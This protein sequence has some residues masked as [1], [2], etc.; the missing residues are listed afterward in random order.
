MA[1]QVAM[2]APA[3]SKKHI[4][5][6]CVQIRS[7][8]QMFKKRN[9]VR[10]AEFIKTE[11]FEEA[12]Q[13]AVAAELPKLME[14][15]L[16][17][18]PGATAAEVKEHEKQQVAKIT[19]KVSKQR[20]MRLSQDIFP[21]LEDWISRNM[22]RMRQLQPVFFDDENNAIFEPLNLKRTYFDHNSA[23]GER[24]FK[25][26]DDRIML[27]Q[28]VRFCLIRASVLAEMSHR[29]TVTKQDLAFVLSCTEPLVFQAE[30][31]IE[32]PAKEEAPE[33]VAAKPQKKRARKVAAADAADPPV[34]KRARKAAAAVPVPAVP[35]QTAKKS[36]AGKGKRASAKQ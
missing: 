12:K 27:E 13:K 34:P 25:K 1:T 4:Q 2:P 23:K 30:R 15:Y 14:T 7:V 32:A 16:E 17:T 21:L 19:H 22:V 18:F 6:R 29:L 10:K 9:D 24:K 33:V 20:C 36:G 31:V 26:E 28:F 8:K 3:P 35:K 5:S 11:E